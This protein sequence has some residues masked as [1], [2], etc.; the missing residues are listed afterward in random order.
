MRMYKDQTREQYAAK[1]AYVA[2]GKGIKSGTV[3]GLF[4]KDGKTI[5]PDVRI[6]IDEALAKHRQALEPEN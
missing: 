5:R 3:I 6:L 4:E 1:R 2:R